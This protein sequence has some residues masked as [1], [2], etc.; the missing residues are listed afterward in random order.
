MSGIDKI[1]NTILEDARNDANVTAD[2]TQKQ[3]DKMKSKIQAEVADEIGEIDRQANKRGVEIEMREKTMMELEVRRN[4][5]KVKRMMINQAFDRAYAYLCDLDDPAYSDLVVSLLVS[6][7]E[8]GN[9]LVVPGKDNRVQQAHVD[10]ANQQ[11]A[12]NGKSGELT[13]ASEAGSFVGGFILSQGGIE[14]NVTF[15]MLVKQRKAS[16]ENTVADMLFPK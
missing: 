11:L 4:S 1:I 3:I 16:L 14:T 13:L 10:A 9:E 2:E 15:D 8:S 6:A 7:A 5:L 12:A